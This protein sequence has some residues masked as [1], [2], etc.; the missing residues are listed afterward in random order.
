MD[1]KSKRK[2]S[3]Y[4]TITHTYEQIEVNG[5]VATVYKRTKWNIEDNDK[6]FYDHEIQMSGL[7]GGEN[8]A[9][10]HFR[11]FVTKEN[12]TENLVQN[13]LLVDEL[14]KALKALDENDFK[15]IYYIFFD[16]KTE[17]QCAEKI[18]VSQQMISRKKKRILKK[19]KEILK[20]WL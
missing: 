11:E 15:I 3:V 10:E 9:F 8:N 18:G 13:K 20:K 1:E 7:I 4:N 16:N 19:L 17:D 12:S 5:D 14:Y 6:S 2:I